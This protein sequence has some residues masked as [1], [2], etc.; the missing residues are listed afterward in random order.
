MVVWVWRPADTRVRSFVSVGCWIRR[1]CGSGDQ[2]TLESG[3]CATEGSSSEGAH[4]SRRNL[5]GAC[6]GGR[7]GHRYCLSPC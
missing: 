1:L 4:C 2:Q 6:R 5:R 3:R 7:R